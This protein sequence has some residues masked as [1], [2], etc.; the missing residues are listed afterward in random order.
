MSNA[1]KIAVVLCGSGFKDGSE[2]RESVGV[3]WALSQHPQL[4]VQCFALNEAQRDVVNCLTGEPVNESRNQ[5][6]EAARIAR[7]QVEDLQKLDPWAFDALII[8][9]GFGAAKNLCTFALEGAKGHTHP[10]LQQKIEGFFHAKKPIGAVCIAPMTL[11]LALPHRGLRLTLG[12]ADSGAA[13]A[14]VEL[15]HTHVVTRADEC[16]VDEPHKVVTSPAYMHDGAPLVE[17][18]RGIEKLV[19]AVVNFL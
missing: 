17:I 10:Q 9:G 1:K 15:G 5:L 14:C 19:A 7:G 4:R 12:G 13:Q 11:A 2:I 3:L 18:F 16:C 8:P 6:V